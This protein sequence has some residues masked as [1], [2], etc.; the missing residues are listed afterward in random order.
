MNW[1]QFAGEAG[2]RLRQDLRPTHINQCKGVTSADT[3]PAV[4]ASLIFTGLIRMHAAMFMEVVA[5]P[6]R[7]PCR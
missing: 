6:M 2:G 3:P 1:A 5:M 4:E 7:Q